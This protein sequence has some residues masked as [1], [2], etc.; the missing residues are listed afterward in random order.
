MLI[1]PVDDELLP[2]PA[3]KL[4]PTAELPLHP[5]KAKAEVHAATN[6]ADFAVNIAV[7]F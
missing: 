2:D 5:A 1:G 4:G 3:G 7:S 6:A